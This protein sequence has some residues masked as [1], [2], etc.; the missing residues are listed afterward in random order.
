MGTTYLERLLLSAYREAIR[1]NDLMVAD[2]V[3]SAIE[4]CAAPE[5]AMTDAVIEAYCDLAVRAAPPTGT[6][7]RV[8]IGAAKPRR[9]RENYQL[10]NRRH[11]VWG[12]RPHD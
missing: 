7:D 1:Q 5:A 2:I 8:V 9:H 4:A 12:L 6:S 11:A 3:L 10:E